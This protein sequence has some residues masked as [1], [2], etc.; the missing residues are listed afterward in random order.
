MGNI[1]ENN[2]MKQ[3]EH[4][5]CKIC[6]KY[7]LNPVI[8][9]CGNNICQEHVEKKIKENNSQFYECDFCR[10]SHE[11]PENGFILN[12]PFIEMMNMNLNLTEGTKTAKKVIKDL[13]TPNKEID[14]IAKDPE[15]FIYDYFAKEINKIDLRREKL[16]SKINDISDE[17]IAKLKQMQNDSKSNLNEKKQN[18]ID[19]NKFY[20]KKLSEEVLNWN[21]EIR[22][23]KLDKTRLEEIIK[24][25][26]DLIKNNE[27]QSFE[28]TFKRKNKDS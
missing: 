5:T 27:K 24:E 19:S 10:E 4:L 8:L 17:M 7:Y 16:I 23:P 11:V 22:N 9:P 28:F 25:S 13:E 20:L 12:R 26:I 15:N 6:Q 3:N 14:L 18:L 2:Q 21:E 1:L